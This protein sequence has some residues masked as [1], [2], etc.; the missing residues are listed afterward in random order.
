MSI[1]DISVQAHEKNSYRQN[2]A[3]TMKNRGTLREH[4]I[5][6][7]L[8]EPNGS[9]TKYRLAKIT[10]T[11]FPW[12]HEFLNKLQTQK[13]VKDTTVTNYTGL[14]NYWLQIKTKPKQK[15]EYMHKNPLD[16]IQTSKLQ[17]ALTT[18]QA[19]NLV[20]HYLFPSRID[21]YIKKEDT[22]KWHKEITTTEGLVGKG[23]LRLL[24]TEDNHVFYGAFKRQDLTV[25]SI[26]QLIV[27]L[28]QE[29]G[30]CTEAAEKLINK[31]TME[32]QHA[33][34]VN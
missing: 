10:E 22:E 8:V 15:K 3:N 24:I 11:S 1:T 12:T 17:Y 30:V 28:L 23:N 21:L 34:S 16:L 19:E 6:T 26:P 2:K 25:V 32:Q 20:Q 5:R 14:I 9:L 7:L 31:I 27:D 4:I 18:Y 13:L 29:C 33:I